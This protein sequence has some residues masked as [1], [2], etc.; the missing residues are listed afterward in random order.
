MAKEM[1]QQKKEKEKNEK[2]RMG[3]EDKEPK[4]IPGVYNRDGKIR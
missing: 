2:K 4:V 3:V 1:E